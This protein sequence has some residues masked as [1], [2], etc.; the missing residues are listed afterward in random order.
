MRRPCLR[1]PLLLGLLSALLKT[2]LAGLALVVIAAA[3]VI[4]LEGMEEAGAVTLKPGDILVNDGNGTVIKI[5]PATGTQTVI[6][7]GGVLSFAGGMAIDT[8]GQI[9]VAGI[10]NAAGIIRIDPETGT[11]TVVPIV[12]GLPGTRG[13]A[14]V[15]KK[16]K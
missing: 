15:L 13:L 1:A 12:G 6:T 10:G 9:L 4:S 7:T 14:V 5:D 8:D 16:K 11:L 3:L 2:S